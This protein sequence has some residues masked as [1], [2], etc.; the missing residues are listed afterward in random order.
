M[1]TFLRRKLTLYS[2]A[3][4]HSLNLFAVCDN[5]TVSGTVSGNESGC[6]NYS[7]S[8]ITNL[9]FPTGGTGTLEYQ[10][11]ISTDGNSWTN[12]AFA[13]N[14]NYTP[15][16]SSQTTFYHR[17][18]RR[19][20]CTVYAGTSNMITKTVYPLPADSITASGPVNFCG[21]VN[22]MLTINST[23][24]RTYQWRHDNWD[25]VGATNLSYT[26][27]TAAHY[28]VRETITATGC[29]ALSNVIVVTSSNNSLPIIN[30]TITSNMCDSSAALLEAGIGEG[31]TG[32]W[33]ENGNILPGATYWQYMTGHNG[34]LF[35]YSHKCM[36]CFF[37][38]PFYFE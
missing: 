18:E 2:F 14:A 11:E 1:K 8:M 7:P 26:A 28:S 25:I 10:W 4:L 5:V 27:T 6:G 15:G 34:N 32:Q 24:G 31:S 12:I 37:F 38:P 13:T 30:Y 3:L 9:S 17:L 33:F 16:W 22:V 35:M 20:G 23:P 21:Q 19:N 29:T 36:R